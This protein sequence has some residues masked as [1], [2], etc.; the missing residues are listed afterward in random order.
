MGY[1][2]T[3][4]HVI[5]SAATWEYLDP[6]DRSLT[7]TPIV[8]DT[9]G[10]PPRK[11]WLIDNLT[12]SRDGRPAP[13]Y[14][15]GTG[16]LDD[17]PARLREMDELG[18]ETQ[19]IFPTIFLGPVGGRWKVANALAKAYNRWSESSAYPPPTWLSA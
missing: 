10:G 17:V 15:P 6:A 19:I 2:D 14:P 8:T 12:Y 9:P 16:N 3:D 13:G 7:P 1:I 5:E 4:T 11:L 18:V